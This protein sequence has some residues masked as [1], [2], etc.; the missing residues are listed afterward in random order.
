[1]VAPIDL[2]GPDPSPIDHPW[3]VLGCWV[4]DL[5]ASQLP[6]FSNWNTSWFNND[7]AFRKGVGYSRRLLLSMRKRPTVGIHKGGSHIRYDLQ[8]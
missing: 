5:T 4:H 8:Y 2:L 6:Y 7:N 3:D 1:M